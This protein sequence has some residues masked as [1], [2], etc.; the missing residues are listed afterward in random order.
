[1]E[2]P[3]SGN[4]IPRGLNELKNK[5]GLIITKFEIT[6]E[7]AKHHLGANTVF[8]ALAFEQGIDDY[9]KVI[10]LNENYIAAK[11][12]STVALEAHSLY[13]KRMKTGLY[14]VQT[15]IFDFDGKRAHILQSI[16]KEEN[17]IAFQETL[18]ISFDLHS[19]RTCKFDSSIA[20]RY[21]ELYEAQKKL[22]KPASLSLSLKQ[23][24][25]AR[26]AYLS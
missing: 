17:I 19:R 23:R 26:Y 6:R 25:S 21:I 12:K 2:L 1:M 24:L 18:S 15:R 3:F 20:Q 9:K 5:T 13:S 14:Q 10:G 16:F 22:P 7:L 11:K 4:E 8:Y